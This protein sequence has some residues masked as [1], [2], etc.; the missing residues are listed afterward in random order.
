[1]FKYKWIHSFKIIA[2]KVKTDEDRHEFNTIENGMEFGQVYSC[3]L[4]YSREFLLLFLHWFPLNLLILKRG[5]FDF[6]ILNILIN[7]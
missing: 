7:N 1:M 4:G 6:M 2:R 5:I 3:S